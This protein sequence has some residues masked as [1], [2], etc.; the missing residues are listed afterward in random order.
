MTTR[1]FHLALAIA[2][3]A[4][5][6][7]AQAHTPAPAQDPAHA[8][9]TSQLIFASG[10]CRR[11]RFSTGSACTTSPIALGLMISTR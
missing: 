5:P 1:P 8:G 6:L 2:L 11:T 3:L 7:G 4:A 10:Q 9:V